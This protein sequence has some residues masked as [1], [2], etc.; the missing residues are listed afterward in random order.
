MFDLTQN[1]MWKHLKDSQHIFLNNCMIYLYY[2]Y[3]NCVRIE[4]WFA[5]GQTQTLNKSL[6]SPPG[7]KS[8]ANM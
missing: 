6:K 3:G 5:V 8:E 1:S 7:L 4:F 2:M